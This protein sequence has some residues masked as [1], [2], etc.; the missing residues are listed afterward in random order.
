MYVCHEMIALRVE[1]IQQYIEKK[2]TF[3][4]IKTILG[5]STKTIRQRIAK[6][7][8]HWPWGLEQRRPWP[9]KCASVVNRTNQETEDLICN[10]A[11]KHRFKWPIQLWFILQDEHWIK[12]HYTTIFRILRRNWVRY[13][14][15][16]K[17]EKRKPKLY[18]KQMPWQEVQI[19]VSFPYEY[20]RKIFT[21]NAI[22][23]CSRILHTRTYDIHN[24]QAS[25]QFI[26]Y[27]LIVCEFPIDTIRTDQGR[28]FGKLF[29]EHLTKLWINHI[30]N[31]AYTP[32]S[33]WKVER[34]HR[35][36]KEDFVCWRPYT[37]TLDEINYHN[38]LWRHHY[39]HLRRHTWLA[40]NGLTPIQK[41][42]YCVKQAINYKLW[43]CHPNPA[44]L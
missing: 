14:Q 19:D 38:Q 44:T 30:K 4:D 11:K 18:A 13:H 7:K 6:Y 33:N 5:K 21:Y 23:D 34:Y 1:L 15:Y 27:L 16:Y 40:M 37:R 22:D 39:N 17:K 20:D 26:D 10:L 42:K 41:L 3:A 28:E 9:R 25:I 12:L 29:T 2:R 43:K 36:W 32:E 8:K 35:T 24:Q 31:P